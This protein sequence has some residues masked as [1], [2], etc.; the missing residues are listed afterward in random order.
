MGWTTTYI[1]FPSASKPKKCF[2]SLLLNASLGKYCFDDEPLGSA[3]TSRNQFGNSRENTC[4]TQLWITIP[5]YIQINIGHMEFVRWNPRVGAIMEFGLIV[6]QRKCNSYGGGYH[7]DEEHRK[8][9]N[10]PVTPDL[11]LGT[12]LLRI[13]GLAWLFAEGENGRNTGE[14]LGN[15]I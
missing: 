15:Q 9:D 7:A 13:F 2:L 10:K 3:S 5:D 11:A 6:Q 4:T 14:K 1:R 8:E 12:F